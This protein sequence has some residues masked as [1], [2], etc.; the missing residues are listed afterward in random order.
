MYFIVLIQNSINF[1]YYRLHWICFG[2]YLSKLSQIERHTR[3]TD[4]QHFNAR[5]AMWLTSPV[6]RHLW[7][8]TEVAQYRRYDLSRPL[9]GLKV[10]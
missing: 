3:C 9:S 5:S 1:F 2:F 8:T 7:M 4:K 6:W 10:D